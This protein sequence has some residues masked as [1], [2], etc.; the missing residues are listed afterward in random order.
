MRDRWY[1]SLMLVAAGAI[2][3]MIAGL[4]VV[5]FLTSNSVDGVPRAA[6]SFAALGDRAVLEKAPQLSRAVRPSE[7]ARP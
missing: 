7:T 3:L 2:T 5:E 1:T 6:Q 4:A